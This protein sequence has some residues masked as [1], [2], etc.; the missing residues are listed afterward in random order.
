MKLIL[1]AESSIGAFTA[2]LITLACQQPGW[3][4]GKGAKSAK[5]S[6]TEALALYAKQDFEGARK[7]FHNLVT[8][9][10]RD[11]DSYYYLGNCYV[12]L[13]NYPAA[14][15]E[16]QRATELAGETTTGAYSRNAMTRIDNILH[17]A[18]PPS[19]STSKAAEAKIVDSDAKEGDEKGAEKKD[20]RLVAAEAAAQAKIAEGDKAAQRILDDAQNRCKPIKQEEDSVASEIQANQGR[21]A[22][23]EVAN[24]VVNESRASYEEQIKNI[25][26]P[27]KRRAQQI[28]D[29]AKA[30]AERAKQAALGKK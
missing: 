30:E 16:Y 9:N 15:A 3:T 29:A 7:L 27:A 19:A 25:M 14:R 11:A 23:T 26:E 28:K 20:P 1:T 13:R 22:G 8:A 24:Q 6:K 21:N 12:G 5:S 10:P 2:V 17:P 18:P 4:A